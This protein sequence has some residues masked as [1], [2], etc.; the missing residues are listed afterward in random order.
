MSTEKNSPML[1]KEHRTIGLIPWAAVAFV[2][3]LLLS[4]VALAGECES[5]EE[6]AISLDK[7]SSAGDNPAPPPAGQYSEPYKSCLN[8][9]FHYHNEIGA[10]HFNSDALISCYQ[11]N[12]SF[13][14]NMELVIRDACKGN[15]KGTE[16]CSK[17]D[18]LLLRGEGVALTKARRAVGGSL[19]GIGIASV[20]LGAVHMAYPIFKLSLT[21]DAA[22][23]DN[24]GVRVECEA[25]PLGLGI[26]LIG[27]GSISIGFGGAVLTGKLSE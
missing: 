2:A 18:R 8:L 26:S 14:G 22:V 20:V 6:Y 7:S 1:M 24:Y 5:I 25:H 16:I 27:L 13:K 19:I 23:C 11:L 15:G 21:S 9:A 17:W 3:P 4:S 12:C 10:E